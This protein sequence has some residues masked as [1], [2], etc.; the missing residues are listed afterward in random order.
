M[1]CSGI[2][3]SLR[4][5]IC[6]VL[7]YGQ[8]NRRLVTQLKHSII[9]CTGSAGR[10]GTSGTGDLVLGLLS[11][12]LVAVRDNLTLDLHTAWIVRLCKQNRREAVIRMTRRERLGGKRRNRAGTRP[13]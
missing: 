12:G 5:Y 10:L 4:Q 1:A 6:M 7:S 8:L 2:W 9:P 11:L 3:F 13:T